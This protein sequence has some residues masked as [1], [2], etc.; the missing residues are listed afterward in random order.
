MAIATEDLLTLMQ[1]LSPSYP[2]GTFSYSHGVEWAIESGQIVDAATLAA[3]VEDVLQFGAGAADAR[4]LTA[5]HGG[6]DSA[7]AT[8]RAFAGSTERLKETVLQGVAFCDTTRAVWGLDLPALTYPVAVG[9]AAR[10]RGLPLEPVSASY[11]HAF[12]A[13]L[14]TVG[15]RLIPLGQTQGQRLIHSI[16]RESKPGCRVYTKVDELPKPLAGLGICI[17]STPKGVLSDRQAREQH[18]GG[19]LLCT[20]E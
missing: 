7:D 2:V 10:M 6:D 14:V 5:A 1:W 17:V 20:V 3:W 16:R 9:T 18:V 4:L 11:L 13:N 12:A 19:E 15:M 8:A